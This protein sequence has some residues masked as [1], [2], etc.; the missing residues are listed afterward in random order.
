M[1]YC[2]ECGKNV[3]ELHHIIFRSQASYMSNININFKYLCADCHRGDNGPHMSKKKNLEY[4]L[5]LQKKLFGLFDKDYFTEK[6]IKEILETTI[7]EARKITKKLK[8]YKEGYE[9][10]DIIQR[11]MGG[12]LYVK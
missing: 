4:K 9:K 11:L 8:L 6:E 7:S 1:K 2:E 5:E 12:H 3:V 10:I